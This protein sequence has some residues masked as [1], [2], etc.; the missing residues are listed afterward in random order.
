MERHVLQSFWFLSFVPG[1]HFQTHCCGVVWLHQSNTQRSGGGWILW[2]PTIHPVI[3]LAFHCLGHQRRH[4]SLSSSSSPSSSVGWMLGHGILFQQHIFAPCSSGCVCCL[5]HGGKCV[6]RSWRPHDTICRDAWVPLNGVVRSWCTSWSR[7]IE[8]RNLR[9][10]GDRRERSERWYG[11]G[12]TS[13]ECHL[14]GWFL[15]GFCR[16]PFCRKLVHDMSVHLVGRTMQWWKVVTKSFSV[17]GEV[18]KNVGEMIS[19]CTQLTFILL[20][21]IVRRTLKVSFVLMHFRQF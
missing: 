11:P 20:L 2:P 21:A 1:S 5:L 18:V 19:K 12:S 14:F 7:W 4:L 6:C 15:F 16:L 8:F 10:S 17:F 3:C 9:I 13:V